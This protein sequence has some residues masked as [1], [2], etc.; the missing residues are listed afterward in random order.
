MP[1]RAL[2]FLFLWQAV[3]RMV[4]DMSMRS[5]FIMPFMG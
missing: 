5:A 4:D 2:V 1:M 3:R